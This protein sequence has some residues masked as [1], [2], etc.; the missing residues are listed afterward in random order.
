MNVKL[1]TAIEHLKYEIDEAKK[2]DENLDKA[3]WSE[4]EGVLLSGNEAI[5]ILDFIEKHQK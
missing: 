3:S 1:Q 4:Q 2:Y 5:L